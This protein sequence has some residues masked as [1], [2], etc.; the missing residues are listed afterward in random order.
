MK[1]IG[2]ISIFIGITG[3]ILIFYFNYKVYLKY[4][5][6]NGMAQLVTL[7]IY[8]QT[9]KYMLILLQVVGLTSG[10][11]SIRYKNTKSGYIGFTICLINISILLSQSA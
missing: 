1:Y 8:G 4:E 5:E 3:S 11:I 10:V 7:F 6:L 9:N 2:L